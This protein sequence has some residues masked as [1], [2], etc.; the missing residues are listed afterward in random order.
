MS[1]NPV[2]KEAMKLETSLILFGDATRKHHDYIKRTYGITALEMQL[3]Q[4]AVINGPQKMKSV[5]EHFRIKLSTFTSTIDKAERLRLLK[6]VNS[7]E[8]R[9]VVYL[10][11]SPKGRKIYEKYANSLQEMASE[12]QAKMNNAQFN[13]FLEGLEVFNTLSLQMPIN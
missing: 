3:I 8:D 4:F 13:R 10:D 9:R 1:L 5:S 6:R 12:V 2:T 7:K 11:V